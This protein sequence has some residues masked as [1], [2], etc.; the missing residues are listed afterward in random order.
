MGFIYWLSD[1]PAEDLDGASEAVSWLPLA[2]VLV[3]VALYSVLSVFVLRA[4]VVFGSLSEGI[5]AYLTVFV[6]LIYGILDEIHQSSVEGR[7]SE[8]GDVAADVFGAVVVVV[9]WFLFRRYRAGLGR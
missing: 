7:V 4:L 1:R 3:H 2:S 5:M 8:G 9:F 6:A